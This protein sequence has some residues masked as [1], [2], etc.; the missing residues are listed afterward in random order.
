M[1]LAC[2]FLAVGR[3][4][5]DRLI[6]L[7]INFP[8]IIGAVFFLYAILILS[9][10]KSIRLNKPKIL[11]YLFFFLI[12]VMNIFLWPL[13]KVTEYGFEKWINFCLIIVPV[14][15][16]IIE[17]YN[18]KSVLRTIYIL[19]GVCIFLAVL[20]LFGLSITDRS[21]GR[22]AALGGGPIVFARWMGFGI[23]SLA[24]LPIKKYLFLRYILCFILFFLMLSTGSRGP[25]LALFLIGII[26]LILNF[27]SVLVKF[28]VFFSILFLTFSLT[29]VDQ[30]IYELGNIERVFMNI[31]KKG[32]S[33]QSTSTRKNLLSGSIILIK[34]YP[35]GVGSGNWE[36]A[37]DKVSPSHLM[38]SQYP[39][40]L[41]IEVACEYGIHTFFILLL[42]FV[43]ILKRV[44]ARSVNYGK[45]S[46]YPLLFYLFLFL[47]L[48]SFV[49]GM[50]N[51]S[52]ILFIVIAFILIEKPLCK[53][54]EQLNG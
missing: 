31:S 33:A 19:L 46:L 16:I 48:N 3:M 13:H 17:K 7:G 42:L 22:I 54:K 53:N 2:F 36:P 21:D 28:V 20:G 44:Y 47:L 10:I 38:P 25:F 37:L 26:Y 39:H 18:Y 51:D 45:S 5:D 9:S 14:S 40:N 1:F 29:S 12:I 11:F 27:K 30:K 34:N 41:L 8:I 15:V 4:Y 6:I 24:F 35:F 23:I 50:I 49:S 52:R 32:G 43:Y